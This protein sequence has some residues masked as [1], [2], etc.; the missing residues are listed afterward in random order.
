MGGLSQA[1]CIQLG[2]KHIYHEDCLLRVLK[3]KWSGPRINFEFIKC[4]VCKERMESSHPKAF[5]YIK[6]A[7]KLEEQIY[8]M[9]FKRGKHEGID[10]DDRLKDPPYNGD[11]QS[12]AVARLSYY[13]CYK[14]K[15]PY[16]GGL[17]S[18]ENNQQQN[19]Q[20]FKRDELVCA[21]C[22]A[23]SVGGGI[24]DC[25]T[26]GRDY[27]EFKCKFCCNVAQWFCWGTTHFC[28]D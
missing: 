7:M 15:K 11:L 16:F 27:I 4:P 13:M 5:K 8:D 3:G 25:K 10:K 1:P 24:K 6:E 18:C 2:C 14:C 21:A 22:S 17:K 12:Y 20:N 26:H 28:D 19:N 9:A 23:D